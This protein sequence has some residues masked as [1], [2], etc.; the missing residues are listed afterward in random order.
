MTRATM[1]AS[2][3]CAVPDLSSTCRIDAMGEVGV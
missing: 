1:P 2:E 3:L